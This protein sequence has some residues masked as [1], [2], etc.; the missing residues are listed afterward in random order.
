[1]RPDRC[2]TCKR[3]L[4]RSSRANRRYWL[5]LHAVADKLRPNGQAYSAETWHRYYASRFLGCDDVRLPSGKV[6]TIPRS[7]SALDTG[8][9]HEYATQ[10]EAD[11]NER[12]VFLED[13]AFA[14]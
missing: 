8:E 9:F 10:V 5:I 12:G 14:A 7:T 2:P 11:A 3:R 1:M 13:E 4:T 6:L